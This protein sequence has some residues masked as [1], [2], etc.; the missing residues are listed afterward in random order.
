MCW[1]PPDRPASTT[2][3]TSYCETTQVRDTGLRGV[4]TSQHYDRLSNCCVETY[5]GNP[6]VG[7]AHGRAAVKEGELF[8]LSGAH[9]LSLACFSLLQGRTLPSTPRCLYQVPGPTVPQTAPSAT[10]IAQV[11]TCTCLCPLLLSLP[12]PLSL[13]ISLPPSLLQPVSPSLFPCLSVQV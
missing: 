1:A 8:P 7:V 12:L 2:Q 6:W 10:H 13:Y 9:F 3:T 4:A 5:G 11:S